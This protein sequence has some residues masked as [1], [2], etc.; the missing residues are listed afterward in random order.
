MLS[1]LSFH[2]FQPSNCTYLPP[3]Q[4]DD[5]NGVEDDADDSDYD[6]EGDNNDNNVACLKG[7]WFK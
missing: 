5:D 6:P 1:M 2:F 7:R 3:T 4:D